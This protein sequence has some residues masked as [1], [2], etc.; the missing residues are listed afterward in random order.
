MGQK[1]TKRL[2]GVGTLGWPYYVRTE[3]RPGDCALWKGSED[4]TV[5][6]AIWRVAV[7]VGLP[8]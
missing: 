5:T 7:R 1:V 4:T 8:D 6:K 3:D 2:R